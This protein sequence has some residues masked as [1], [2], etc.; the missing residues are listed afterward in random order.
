MISL[1]LGFL[2]QEFGI[3]QGNEWI[4]WAHFECVLEKFSSFVC[5][6]LDTIG[7]RGVHWRRNANAASLLGSA[8]EMRTNNDV[9]LE[10]TAGACPNPPKKGG[11]KSACSKDG[12]DQKQTVQAGMGYQI[13]YSTFPM[14][15]SRITMQLEGVWTHLWREGSEGIERVAW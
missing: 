13:K 15:R 10:T 9:P 5:C 8:C 2:F 4:S 6:L 7:A 3:P 12:P 1:F 14:V 11:K